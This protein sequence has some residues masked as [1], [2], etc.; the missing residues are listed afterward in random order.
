MCLIMM[1]AMLLAA[2]FSQPKCLTNSFPPLLPL[3]TQELFYLDLNNYFSGPNLTIHLSTQNPDVKL[4]PKFSMEAGSHN[5]GSILSIATSSGVL[6]VFISLFR[7]WGS[8]PQ[9][10]ILSTT[11][12]LIHLITSQQ[13]ICQVQSVDAFTIQFHPMGSK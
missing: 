4:D 3:V 6:T 7:C 9:T 5:L 12:P 13:K 1:A 8:P 11:L 10:S 2:V